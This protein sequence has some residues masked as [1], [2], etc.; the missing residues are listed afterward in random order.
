VLREISGPPSRLLRSTGGKS[1]F[2]LVAAAASSS[3]AD[4]M[5]LFL[6]LGIGVAGE[7]GRGISLCEHSCVASAHRAFIGTSPQ[8]FKY[9]RQHAYCLLKFPTGDEAVAMYDIESQL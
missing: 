6:E 1:F 4:F 8:H 2:R 7:T 5:N 9:L 3:T